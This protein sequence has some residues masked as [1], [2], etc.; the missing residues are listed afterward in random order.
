MKNLEII[1]QECLHECD[2]VGIKYGNIEK[3]YINKRLRSTWGICRKKVINGKE[4]F[5]IEI[6]PRLLKEES[7]LS[8]IKD[9]VMH[10]VLHTVNGCHNHSKNWKNYA[11]LI[12]MKYLMLLILF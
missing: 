8:S 11:C 3:I 10:E 9:T 12:N 7:S 5:L 6:N 2:D 1:L 4:I